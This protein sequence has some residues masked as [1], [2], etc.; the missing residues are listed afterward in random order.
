MVL[1]TSVKPSVES[2]L[3]ETRELSREEFLQLR[4]WMEE[5]GVWDDWDRQ[6]A[7]DAEAGLLDVLLED[8]T[9]IEDNSELGYL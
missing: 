3:S 6:M 5:W 4:K 8:D 2:I 1:E 7:A 9:D